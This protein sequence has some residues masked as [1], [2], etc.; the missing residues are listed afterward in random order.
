MVSSNVYS[1]LP[2]LTLETTKSANQTNNFVKDYKLSGLKTVRMADLRQKSRYAQHIEVVLIQ[3]TYI[4]KG[5]HTIVIGTYYM[6]E[7]LPPP[8]SII[9]VA[10]S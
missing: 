7:S 6:T 3:K 4:K 2:I 10:T 1:L 5:F 8:L 9:K